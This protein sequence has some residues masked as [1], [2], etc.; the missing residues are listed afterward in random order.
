MTQEMM[1]RG[2]EEGAETGRAVQCTCGHLIS[3]AG[4]C[5]VAVREGFDEA[6]LGGET[7]AE[8]TRAELLRGF[9]LT[10][11]DNR[12]FIEERDIWW[13]PGGLV[14]V[15]MLLDRVRDELEG[16]QLPG[17]LRRGFYSASAR[18]RIRGRWCPN[19]ILSKRRADRLRQ[20]RRRREI[21]EEH[22]ESFGRPG[23][24]YATVEEWTAVQNLVDR[25]MRVEALTERQRAVLR[26]EL[27]RE[28]GGHCAMP[29]EYGHIKEGTFRKDLQKLRDTLEPLM[30]GLLGR[31]FRRR[32]WRQIT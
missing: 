7:I 6:L 10:R 28:F 9:D 23:T 20:F 31:P 18:K 3:R 17:E 22:A 19:T 16:V 5:Q 21:R 1:E 12:R 14:E 2:H 24:Y 30:E 11:D 13:V 15:D 32:R 25:V 26:R 29:S 4:T 27:A 8:P